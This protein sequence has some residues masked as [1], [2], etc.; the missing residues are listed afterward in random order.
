ME[1]KP[2]P[3]DETVKKASD[4]LTTSKTVLK[5]LNLIGACG[6]LSGLFFTVL[7]IINFENVR[8]VEDVISAIGLTFGLIIVSL[9]LRKWVNRKLKSLN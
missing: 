1:S 3:I 6:I 4:T 7:L 8:D 9:L 5:T 2:N